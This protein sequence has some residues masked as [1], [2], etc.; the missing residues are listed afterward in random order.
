MGWQGRRICQASRLPGR[1]GAVWALGAR[2]KE[3]RTLQHLSQKERNQP[4]KK[5]RVRG[6]ALYIA[7]DPAFFFAEKRMSDQHQQD[8]RRVFLAVWHALCWLTPRRRSQ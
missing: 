4:G 7:P 8:D 2:G 3:R 1:P 6:K 5:G